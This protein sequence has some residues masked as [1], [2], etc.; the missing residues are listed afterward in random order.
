M[1][2][3]YSMRKIR[4]V[5]RLK[6]EFKLSKRKIAGSV[7]IGASTVGDYLKRAQDAGLTWSEAEKLCDAVVEERLFRR[8]GCNEPWVRAPID[9]GWVH[10]ELRRAGVTLELLWTEYQQ[11][12][13]DGGTGKKPYQYS[14]FCE[15]YAEYRKKMSP[16]MRQTHR[17]GEKAF[18]DFSGKRPRIVDRETGEETE[19]E[20]FVMVLGASNYTYAEA[21]R[22]QQLPDFVGATVRGLEYCGC[23]PE[24]LVPDQL[25]SAVNKPDRYEPEINATYAEVAQ[26]YGTAIVPARPRK[27]KDKA[28][29]E[30]GVLIAQ[31]WILA[32]L[33]NR[34]FSSL[35]ELNVAIREL[36]EKLNTRPFQKLEGCR[37][38]AF[39]KLDR[40]AMKPLPAQRYELG[41]WKLNVGVNIDYHFEYDHRYYSVPCALISA[42]VDVRA[43]AAIV[44]VWRDN[45]RVTSHERSYGPKGTAVTK[46]EHRPHAH[47][48]WGS[49]PPERLVGWAAQTG[50]K[51]AAVVAAILAHPTH[52]ETG[53]RACLGLMRLGERYGANRLEAA[54]A[55]AVAIHNPKYK[56]VEAILKNGLDR[57]EPTKEAEAQPVL[58]ENIRG[59]GYFDREEVEPTNNADEIEA[60][61]LDEERFGIMNYTS[62]DTRGEAPSDSQVEE[63]KTGGNAQEIETRYWMEECLGSVNDAGADADCA[64][65]AMESPAGPA[66]DL[67]A[68]SVRRSLPELI[69]QLRAAW[70]RPRGADRREQW[71]TERG[72][73]ESQADPQDGPSCTSQSACLTVAGNEGEPDVEEEESRRRE[74]MSDAMT[75][76]ADDGW[77]VFAMPRRGEVE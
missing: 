8:L 18:L 57:V 66:P 9:M 6:H 67:V 20:L 52:P 63:A 69:A 54:C 53:R 24:M 46:P 37:R 1:S 29:V 61:Y 59:G 76:E 17:A 48:A 12:V 5:L 2:E 39:E 47:R 36:L 50:P 51:T 25:R 75:C 41:K 11:G 74:C 73:E 45:A 71:V 70:E 22:T 28:K 64:R 65:V 32:C 38:S 43:T 72:G 19:V 3:R 15:L 31:R 44:E 40:P 13:A 33:R 58:H 27:P 23:V 62:A 49:W 4:E 7:G 60:R 26:H 10:T 35:E 14:Q 68:R 16:S 30:G 77:T 55:R 21:V 34:R 42:K 56:S